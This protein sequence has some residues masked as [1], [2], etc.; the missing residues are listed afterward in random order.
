LLGFGE[1]VRL[2]S[3]I[4]VDMIEPSQGPLLMVIYGGGFVAVQLVFVLLYVR[5]L[6]LRGALRL[7]AYE[8]SVT[9]EEIRFSS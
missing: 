6:S 9:W 7:D 5:A 3:G 4:R 2:S 8:L 1:K